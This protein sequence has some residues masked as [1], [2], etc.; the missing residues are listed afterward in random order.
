MGVS[1]QSRHLGWI[2]CSQCGWG[3]EVHRCEVELL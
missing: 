1:D 2:Q 3:C